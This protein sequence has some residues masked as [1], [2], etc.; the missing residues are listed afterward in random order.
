[1][2]TRNEENIA[3]DNTPISTV[4]RTDGEKAECVQIRSSRFDY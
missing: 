2:T 1:M 4:N 3:S